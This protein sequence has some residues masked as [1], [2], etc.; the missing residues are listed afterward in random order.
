VDG[1]YVLDDVAVADSMAKAMEDAFDQLFATVK[2]SPLPEAGLQDRRLLFVAIARGV[3]QYLEN[4][5]AELFSHLVIVHQFGF[6]DPH[7][8][9]QV[10]LNITMER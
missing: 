3:L 1:A 8:V 2:Q 10:D 6:P 5:Q 9:T 7:Q 4:H